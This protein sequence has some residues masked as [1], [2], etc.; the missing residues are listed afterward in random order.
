[1]RSADRSPRPIE[2]EQPTE[3]VAGHQ[4][5]RALRRVLFVARSVSIDLY[6]AETATGRIVRKLVDTALSQHFT[7]L[8]FIGSAGSWSPDSRQF[9]VGG[10]HAGKAVLAILD[11]ANGDVV[12]EI[13]LHGVGEM[14]NPTWSPDGQSIAFSGD[15]RR[16]FGPVHLRPR[17]EL[18]APHHDRPVRRSAAGLVAGR[19]AASR[20]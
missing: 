8:Q 5:R 6:L 17:H 18:L 15:R 1:M 3:R 10:V 16:R 11:V 19:H 4:S 2:T 12:R 13:E 9:V 7:S 14:L 20:L